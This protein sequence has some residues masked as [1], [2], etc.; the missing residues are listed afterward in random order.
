MH[1]FMPPARPSRVRR[2]PLAASLL[3]A[4]ALG[5]CGHA[6]QDGTVPVVAV[7]VL[8]QRTFVERI[9]GDRVE[10]VALIP[11]GASPASYEPSL[12]DLRALERAI[13]YV[14]VGHPAFPYERAWLASL[15]AERPELPVIGWTSAASDA[16]DPHVWLSPARVRELARKIE[17][18]LAR[19]LPEHREEFA[20]NRRAFE[21]ELTGLDDELRRL[22]APHAGQRFLVLH[23]AWGHLAR[24]YGLVQWA[25][26]QH[27]KEPDP[28]TLSRLIEEARAARV[29]TLFTQPQFDPAPAEVVAQ[30]I[31]ARAL[32]LDPLAADWAPNLALAARAIGAAA[33][34]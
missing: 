12:A 13:L 11:P 32:P 18:E 24:E 1:R 17:T 9:A 33:V 20:A 3:L 8:P 15:L 28:A 7:S 16:E 14:K 31:G 30:A 34:P 21:Q 22:L 29:A 25:I 19:L 26:E 27:G 2:S 23:P 5:A 10:T 4:A 6:P